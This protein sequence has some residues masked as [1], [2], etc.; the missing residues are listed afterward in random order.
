MRTVHGGVD[1][2]QWLKLTSQAGARLR[3]NILPKAQSC[4]RQPWPLLRDKLHLRTAGAIPSFLWVASVVISRAPSV[5]GLCAVL[6]GRG[7]A[8][9]KKRVTHICLRWKHPTRF[10][11]KLLQLIIPLLHK[12]R[13]F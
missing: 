5:L 6:S 10:I 12:F 3:S 13:I 11:E 1:T 4:R 2:Q 8:T 9:L 7:L